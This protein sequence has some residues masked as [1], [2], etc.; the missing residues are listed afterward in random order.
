M[1][2]YQ[3]FSQER[4]LP[5]RADQLEKLEHENVCTFHNNL[6]QDVTLFEGSAVTVANQCSALHRDRHRH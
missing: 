3:S 2:T 1:K 5:Q 6:L 4:I